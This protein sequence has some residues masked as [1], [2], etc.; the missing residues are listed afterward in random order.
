MRRNRQSDGGPC[1]PRPLKGRD[2]VGRTLL[3]PELV[4]YDNHA[5]DIHYG[6]ALHDT[7]KPPFAEHGAK[8]RWNIPKGTRRK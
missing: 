6:P 5:L 1:A 8:F 7:W 3:R 2:G 4:A